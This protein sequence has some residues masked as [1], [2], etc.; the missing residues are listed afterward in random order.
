MTKDI[1]ITESQA[2]ST[3][4]EVQ[5]EQFEIEQQA[6]TLPKLLL[7]QPLS[8]LVATDQA[9]YG[10]FIN[11][12]TKE[13]VGNFKEGIE[14]IPLT[15]KQFHIVSKAVM[16]NGKKEFKFVRIDPIK[17]RL[18]ANKRYFDV[19]GADEI[20]RE[21]VLEFFI[22]C[23]KV[24]ALPFIL[25]FKGM[26]KKSGEAFYTMAFVMASASRKMPFQKVFLLT[27]DKTSN[28]K[29]NF[30]IL[31]TKALRDPNA[32]ELEQAKTWYTTM[33]TAKIE[34]QVEETEVQPNLAF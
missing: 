9:K 25:C 16:N 34:E 33:K 30:A 14:I 4:P 17:N 21:V 18:D 6:I 19:E 20:K 2:V 13:V 24:C 22:L 15:M 11:T 10:D 32:E 3:L 5:F 8:D 29:G 26:S 27:A 7:M 1:A 23:P 31:N 28:D 12:L